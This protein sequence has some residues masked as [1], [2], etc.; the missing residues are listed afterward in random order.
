MSESRRAFLLTGAWAVPALLVR[1]P[2]VVEAA[3]AADVRAYG[4]KGNRETKDTRAIQAAIDDAA[5]TGRVVRF[6]P[7][8]Y[9][10]GTLRLRDRTTLSLE[11][12]AVLIASP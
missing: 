7:G 6:P 11:A 12:G 5:A 8:Q 2:R 9:L 1:W 4:A 10:S 3:P